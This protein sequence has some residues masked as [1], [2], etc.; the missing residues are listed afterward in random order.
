[1]RA[2]YDR[3]DGL[4]ER[5]LAVEVV[6]EEGC[7]GR[8]D[9]ARTVASDELGRRRWERRRCE[10]HRFGRAG[11]EWGADDNDAMCRSGVIY[12]LGR[13][14]SGRRTVARGKAVRDR[15]RGDS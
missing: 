1:M 2:T 11:Q 5:S 4:R 9:G 6:G 12:G 15:L 8:G 10:D 13:S 3:R 7:T 14:E